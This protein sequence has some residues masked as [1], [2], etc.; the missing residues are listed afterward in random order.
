MFLGLWGSK[1]LNNVNNC[2]KIEKNIA[3]NVK[4]MQKFLML[5]FERQSITRKNYRV[6]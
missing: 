6:N 5:F 2:Q 4:K 3:K 1:N